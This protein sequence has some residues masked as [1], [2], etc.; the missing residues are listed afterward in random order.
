[1]KRN[2][3]LFLLIV[4]VFWGFQGGCSVS[5][6]KSGVSDEIEVRHYTLFYTE[7]GGY[8][9]R[10][11]R[12][13]TIVSGGTASSLKRVSPSTSQRG[14]F[15]ID[16]IKASAYLVCTTVLS[17]PLRAAKPPS[18][19]QRLTKFNSLCQSMLSECKISIPFSVALMLDKA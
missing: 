4:F 13:A 2:I 16:L 10:E 17:S 3:L 11:F 9:Q 19:L 8:N 18:W 7:S 12:K 15:M 5:E 6:N 14:L 1:M